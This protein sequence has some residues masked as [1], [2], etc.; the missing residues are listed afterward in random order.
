M[1]AVLGHHRI[2]NH[3][4]TYQT[5]VDD[6]RRQR[7]RHHRR[8]FTVL[9]GPL[10]A[11]GHRHEIP[12]RL[13][14]QLF[15]GVIA[16]HHRR[17]PAGLAGALLGR[18]GN[19]PLDPRQIGR[20]FLPPRMRAPVLLRRRQRLAFALRLDLD[21]ADPGLQ[22]QQVQ[23]RVAQLLAG[24]AVLLDSL[25]PQALFQNPDLHLRPGQLLLELG[26]LLGFGKR[27]GRERQEQI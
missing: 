24:R 15:A 27:T 13:Y 2:E 12:G 26:D 11:L 3:P 25:Q 16:D 6:P 17:L 22:I 4:V 1:I 5:L 18:A 19:H 7:R 14:I 10:F 20:Q 8:H 23:L 9:A 21:V